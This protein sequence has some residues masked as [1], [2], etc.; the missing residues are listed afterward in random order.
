MYLTCLET[1][2]CSDTGVTNSECFSLYPL[3]AITFQKNCTT[4]EVIQTERDTELDT[5]SNA[6]SF[7][8]SGDPANPRLCVKYLLWT[9]NCETTGS[10]TTTGVTY[11]T[12][13]TI[14]EICN[15][16]FI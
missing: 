10:C 13:Y 8:L 16:W 5:Y 15:K 12:G 6:L 14:T 2:A 3:S 9:G 1:C 7:R 4:D 11:E